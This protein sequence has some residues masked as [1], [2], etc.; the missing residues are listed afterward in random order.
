M[1]LRS[2]YDNQLD[3]NCLKPQFALTD[4]HPLLQPVITIEQKAHFCQERTIN[5]QH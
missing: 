2:V 4:K 1:M 5:M 3:V